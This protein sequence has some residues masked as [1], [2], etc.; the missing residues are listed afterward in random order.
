MALKL[1]FYGDP[2]LRRPA[3]KFTEFGPEVRDIA[4]EMLAMM[5]AERG[6]GLAAQQAGLDKSICVI[7]VPEDYDKDDAGNRMHPD[8]T[9]PLVLVNPLITEKNEDI[10]K[11]EEGCL[12][13]PGINGQIPRATR[14][15]LEFQ[16]MQ[17]KSR[18]LQLRDF[19]AR[20][21]QHEVDHLNGVLFI[22]HMSKVKRM[23]IKGKLRKLKEETEAHLNT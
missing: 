14:I 11:A 12:S 13:F 7:S 4:Q 8:V 1:R 17:G 15:S 23:A 6:V 3:V 2:I 10:E 16:D 5:K 22:D 9:M 20:V 18:T 19:L 21:V